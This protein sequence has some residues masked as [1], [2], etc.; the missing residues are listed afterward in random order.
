M[1]RINATNRI[2]AEIK[3]QVYFRDADNQ[4][5][6]TLFNNDSLLVIPAAIIDKS[7]NVTKQS[8]LLKI[9]NHFNHN[10]IM[11][12]AN[13]ENILIYTQITIVNPKGTIIRFY[14]SQDIIIQLG[15]RIAFDISLND[16]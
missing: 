13:A 5:I 9:D 14:S 7:G 1:L 3:L 6:V 16:L 10:Q 11:Q 8:Q 15:L 4:V 2:P 12:L